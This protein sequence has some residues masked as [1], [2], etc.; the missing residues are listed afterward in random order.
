MLV[1][2]AGVTGN[3]GQKLIDALHARGHQVRGLARNP[4][5]LTDARRAKLEDFIVAK[6][7]YD[8]EALDR[9]CKGADAVIS[10]YGVSPTEL[11]FDGQ[12]LLLRAAERA[13]INRFILSTWNND[14]SRDPLGKHESY[15]PYI[16][17]RRIAELSSPIKPLYIFT[18]ALAEVFWVFPDHPYGSVERNGYWNGADKSLSFWGDGNVKIPWTTE[19]D[20]AEFSAAI[21]SRDD[22]VEGGF[23]NTVSGVH[24]VREFAAAYEKVKGKKVGLKTR[25]TDE[26]LKALAFEGRKAA[27][28]REFYK[29]SGFFFQLYTNNGSWDMEKIDNEKLD[30]RPTSLE[31]FLRDN[32]I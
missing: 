32:D 10:A 7:H 12:L 19:Q 25:G 3:I 21:I 1:L 17:F 29:Y 15:D 18:G 4:S 28:S 5:K 6:N 26:D 31:D 20:A 11:A 13:N 30:V 14:W 16:A 8:I 23:W 27:S 2:V 24:T 9:A 22:A